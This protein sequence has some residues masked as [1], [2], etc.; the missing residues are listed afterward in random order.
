M[1]EIT[2][3]RTLEDRNDT[4][5]DRLGRDVADPMGLDITTRGRTSRGDRFEP[6]AP[7]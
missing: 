4:T 2:L 1:H 3:Q 5:D 7:M 6:L